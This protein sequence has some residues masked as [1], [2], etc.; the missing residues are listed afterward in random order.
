MQLTF[1]KHYVQANLHSKKHTFMIRQEPGFCKSAREVKRRITREL[2]REKGRLLDH[3]RCPSCRIKGS[4]GPWGSY[5]RT[6][7]LG[8]AK[9]RLDIEINVPRVRCRKCGHTHAVV[10]RVH[11]PYRWYALHFILCAVSYYLRKGRKAKAACERFGMAASTLYRWRRLIEGHLVWLVGVTEAT[12]EKMRSLPAA[13][14]KE[15]FLPTFLE[16]YEIVFTEH[17]RTAASP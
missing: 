17:E 15:W 1:L 11:V 3:G 6:E 13:V 7:R 16:R 8:T 10:I 5:P 14:D 4:L 9:E 12:E 2:E